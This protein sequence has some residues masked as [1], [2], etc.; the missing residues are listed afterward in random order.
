MA[1]GAHVVAIRTHRWD[2]DAI[3][4]HRAL[5]QVPGIELVVV[6]HNRPAGLD[7]PLPA[8]DI[9]D[10]WVA[11]QGLRRVR[12]YGWRCGDYFLY[13]VRQARP[14]AGFIWLIEPDVHFTAPA[15][16]F[17]NL[18][19][20]VRTDVLG[21]RVEEMDPG[22][23]FSRG[24]PGMKP[25]RSIFALT[26]FSGKAA[27]RL[28]DLRRAYS[29]LARQARF[30]TNDE[31][32]CFS[33]AVADPD[34]TTGNMEEI[35]PDWLPGGTLRP[36]PDILLDTLVGVTAPGIH[37]PVRA[38]EGFLRAVADRS[39]ANFGFFPAMR[40]SLALLSDDERAVIADRFREH[41]LRALAEHAGKPLPGQHN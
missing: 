33:H 32:F 11:A 13:A 34:L 21:T 30:V 5:S 35:A 25:Y 27:D 4:L 23:R 41:C 28:L 1:S 16:G 9:D 37:H 40:Q 3:R 22:H 29:T 14:Q 19:K 20:D 26:R 2:A 15:A 18:F 6:F 24:L 31:I 10:A 39:G 12:D 38:R 7:L 36:D 8:I 17:F